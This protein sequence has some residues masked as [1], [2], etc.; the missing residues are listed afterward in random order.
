M[1]TL[2]VIRKTD[3]SKTKLTYKDVCKRLGFIPDVHFVTIT[4]AGTIGFSCGKPFEILALQA[5]CRENGFV[6]SKALK[7][8]WL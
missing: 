7:T 4:N 3:G 5:A 6:M 8:V 1:D 2:R